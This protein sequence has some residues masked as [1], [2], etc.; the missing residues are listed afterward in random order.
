MA[1]GSLVL[2]FD[3]NCDSGLE[4]DS[5][6][7]FENCDLLDQA[8]DQFLVKL[9]HGGELLGLDWDSVDF[10]SN[11]ISI[12]QQLVQSAETREC[13]LASPKNGKGQVIQVPPFIM[14]LLAEQKRQQAAQRLQAGKLWMNWMNLVFTDSAGC[15]LTGAGDYHACMRAFKAAGIEG[16]RFHD[17]RHTYAVM[18]IRNGDD[19]KT[20]RG[21]LGEKSFR[22]ILDFDTD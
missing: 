20:V 13:S 19:I 12:H 2:C 14:A 4:V 16:A 21:N 6:V 18:A 8:I 11:R 7:V 22:E 1:A 10:Q 5:K 15:H 9:C 3:V 17:L